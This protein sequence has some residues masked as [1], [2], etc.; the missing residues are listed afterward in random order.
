LGKLALAKAW[1]I[2]AVV[3]A[4]PARVDIHANHVTQPTN[5]ELELSGRKKVL[6]ILPV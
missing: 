1:I 3:L 4:T 5:L 2:V 6:K